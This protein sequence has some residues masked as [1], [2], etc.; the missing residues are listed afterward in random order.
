LIFRG[1]ATFLP[2]P[3]YCDEVTQIKRYREES[4]VSNQSRSL[5][6][7]I[8]TLL[9]ASIAAPRFARAE[10][11]VKKSELRKQ[12]EQMDESVKKLKRTI[13]KAEFDKES[14][15]LISKM[16]QVAITCKGMIPSKAATIPAADRPK[17]VAEYQKGMASLL[18]D[19][20]QMEVAVLSG[21]HE[22]AHTLY[23]K[24]KDDEDKGHDQFMPDDDKAATKEK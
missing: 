2:R 11:H 18:S 19:I 20:C 7:S 12:M 1:A 4:I 23:L 24:I 6:F 9:V 3:C 5:V 16:E 22:K 13:R 10:E 8:I 21:D 14:L 17:Y 15:E